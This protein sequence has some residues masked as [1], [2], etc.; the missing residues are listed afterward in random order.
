[1]TSEANGETYYPSTGMGQLQ[2]VFAM[3]QFGNKKRLDPC[4]LA[5]ALSLDTNTQQD[6]QEFSKLLLCHIEEKTQQNAQLIKMLQ[7]LTQ[8]KYS[9]I[10]W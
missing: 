3:M 6:V 9:Y 5:K 1:M 2:F 10:N 4:N 7:N 8:G